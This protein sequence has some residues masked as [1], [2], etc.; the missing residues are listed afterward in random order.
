M[1]TLIDTVD[2]HVRTVSEGNPPTWPSTRVVRIGTA[3]EAGPA[4]FGR[5]RS[6]TMD[7]DLNIYV[8]DV[9]AHQIQVFD[10]MG[11]HVRTVGR[12]GAGPAEF[13]SPYSL[14]WLGDTLAVLDV[15]NARIGL[16]SRDGGSLGTWRWQP[17]SGPDVHLINGSH[18]DL[19]APV[20]RHVAGGMGQAFIYLDGS[21]APDTLT[22]PAG[23]DVPGGPVCHY[24][25]SEGIAFFGIPFSPTMAVAGGPARSV[26]VAWPD[27]YRIAQ[28]NTAGDTVR[29]LRRTHT[30]VPI[31]DPEWRERTE[32]YQRFLRDYPGTRCEPS[33]QPRPPWKPAFRWIGRDTDERLWVEVYSAEGFV[34]EVFDGEGRLMG[35][36]AA[37]PRDE[38]VPPAMRGNRLAVVTQDAVDVQ[39]VEVYSVTMGPSGRERI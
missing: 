39:F 3:L 10:S 4:S 8:A 11:G 21:T 33:E 36:V 30:A 24:P 26:W 28:V 9:L 20:V 16:F 37:P 15:G 18:R 29:V 12:R 22:L 35:Q 2:G 14:G 32:P 19:Y 34:F 17:L 25:N 38:R 13:A 7:A 1:L 6:V 27:E 31:G 23:P 5:I